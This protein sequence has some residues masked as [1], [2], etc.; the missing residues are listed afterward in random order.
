MTESLKKGLVLTTN[1]KENPK[2][3]GKPVEEPA[4]NE[5]K[6]NNPRKKKSHHKKE[7]EENKDGTSKDPIVFKTN[8]EFQKPVIAG[9]EK[10]RKKKHSKGE[11]EKGNEES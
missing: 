5:N 10:K 7:S 3:K 1:D 2:E 4:N 9:M 11:K 6:E 8:N